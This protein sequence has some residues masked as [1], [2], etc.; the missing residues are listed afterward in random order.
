MSSAARLQRRCFGGG[1]KR[2]VGGEKFAFYILENY[3][4]FF[5]RLTQLVNSRKGCELP[6]VVICVVVVV[7][8]FNTQRLNRLVGNLCRKCDRGYQELLLL[9]LA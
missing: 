5:A 4:A 1:G 8:L 6:A 7:V 3:A 9:E 2:C